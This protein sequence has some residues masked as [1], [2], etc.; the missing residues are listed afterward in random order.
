MTQALAKGRA[1]APPIVITTPELDRVVILEGRN[2]LLA[3]ALA[4]P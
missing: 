4:R 1:P 3:Y 2:R